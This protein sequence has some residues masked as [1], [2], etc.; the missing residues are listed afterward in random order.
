MNVQKTKTL[1]TGNKNIPGYMGKILRINL[2][3]SESRIDEPEDS[4]LRKYIGGAALGIKYIYDEVPPGVSWSDPDNRIF[5]GTG[6]LGGTRVGG[7]GSITVV[8]K[9]ALT[10]GLAS[11]QANGYFG[12][13]LRF[14]GFDAIVLEGASSAWKYLYIHDGMVEFRDASQLAGKD[15]FEVDAAIKKE[16]NKGERN[17]SILSIGPAGENLVKFACILTDLG[18]AAAHNGVGAVL[19]SKKVKAIVVE[20]GKKPIPA[21]DKEALTKAAKAIL[22]N[23]LAGPYGSTTFI[24]GTVG[25]VVTGTK[26]FL[27]VPV[28][29]YTSNVNWMTD[30]VLDTYT[31]K[32]IHSRF[33]AKP[34]PC[35][36]CTAK[37]CHMMEIDEGKYKGRVFEEPE[38]E[39][40]AACS[41]AVGV[42][43]VT[44]TLV[45]ASEID[46]LGLDANESGWVMAWAI[47]C[48]EKGLLTGKDTDGL[49]LTWG[50]GE[51]LM[52]LLKKTA[53]REGFGN[54][55]AE[56]V[57]RAA[58]RVGGKAREL[59]IHTMKGNT[60]RGHDHR[61]VWFEQFDTIVSNTGTLESH[62]MAPFKLLGLSPDYDKFDPEAISTLVAK[63]KGAMLF[64][65]SM[66]TCRY[67][68][69]TALD[70]LC[71]AV[72][73]A[74]GWDLDVAEAMAIGKRAAN[75]ARA[76][77]IRHGIDAALDAPSPRYGS[78]LTD[79][80][81]AGKGIIPHLRQMLKN[82][83][84]E[85][86][87]DEQSGK[88][89][90][91]TLSN[92]GL[93]F[94]IPDLWK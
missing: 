63:V 33:K 86:G 1:E 42:E 11:T 70:L 47:E 54:I 20:R 49:E 19:G 29:N 37:H 16:L 36:A 27:N 45:L 3:K 38:Y 32:N 67:N 88:P 53:H 90:P 82:Y 60:P 4:L 7:S 35:W 14:S 58:E 30:A 83:Y 40:M 56:G 55:L 51:A 10:N 57:M 69:S 12:A 68:S 9:G 79:G 87:W 39:G 71:Q 85:M 21:Y 77:N 26:V 22:S 23:T 76:F 5:I 43:D 73:A 52:S 18:H 6:P 65:D 44:M 94:V 41:T 92:L 61:V 59:A 46:R 34:N 48:Y 62:L 74:T 2:T 31:Y 50:N 8:T 80:P 78:T 15:T 81:S 17:V 84:R 64:E 13:F 24:E 93:D 25:M 28:K 72:N 75:M 89:L 91:Q 66:V